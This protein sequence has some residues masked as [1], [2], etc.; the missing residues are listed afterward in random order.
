MWE[1]YALKLFV[2][3]ARQTFLPNSIWMSAFKAAFEPR[4]HCA[5]GWFPLETDSTLSVVHCSR[6]KMNVSVAAF[7]VQLFPPV[8]LACTYIEVVLGP[9]PGL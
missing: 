5:V 1:L 8:P 2:A 6:C 3:G 4:M 7:Q 9:I